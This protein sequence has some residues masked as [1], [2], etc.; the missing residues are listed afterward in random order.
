MKNQYVCH[1]GVK[2]MKWGVRKKQEKVGTSS[3]LLSLA[4]KAPNTAQ[5][6]EMYRAASKR[7]AK[8]YQDKQANKKPMS[9]K[10]KVAIGL[11]AGLAVGIGTAAAI[12]YGKVGKKAVSSIIDVAPVSSSR[13]R[14]VKSGVSSVKKSAKTTN[15]GDLKSVASVA[16]ALKNKNTVWDF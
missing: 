14:N 6:K 2:G 11:A 4:S 3:R 16:D 15:I 8:N 9:T 12:K 1:A 13:S 10:K 5:G 7:S